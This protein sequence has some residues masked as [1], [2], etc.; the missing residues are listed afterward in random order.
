MDVCRKALIFHLSFFPCFF[1][2]SFPLWTK[3]MDLSHLYSC[4]L[5]QW[6]TEEKME[7]FRE[8]R[9]GDLFFSFDHWPHYRS[10]CQR[11]DGNGALWG[12]EWPI[13][14]FQNIP[15][16]ERYC[17]IFHSFVEMF[18]IMAASQLCL[19]T[20]RGEVRHVLLSFSWHLLFLSSLVGFPNCGNPV[21]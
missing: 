18:A 16:C 3:K 1:F 21:I 9:R 19:M 14:P 10:F 15:L 8:I 6:E 5:L 2:S 7:W 12:K 20:L 4:L 11:E 17:C 13:H